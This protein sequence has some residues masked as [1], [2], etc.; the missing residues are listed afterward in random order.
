MGDGCLMEGISHEVCSIAGTFGLG[1][2]IVFYDDNDI[3]IDGEVKGWF[4]DNT[5]ERFESYGWHVIPHM[6]GHDSE[7]IKKAII[8]A[9]AVTDKPTIIC[10]KTKIGWGSPNY[11]G[12]AKTHGEALGEAEVAEVRKNLNW[13]SHP[14]LFQKNIIKPGMPVKKVK[15]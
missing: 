14:L 6:D 3:S 13:P 5:P 11:A 15:N 8:A 1:K 10:C 4:T 12:K 2:L 9:Q 7:A